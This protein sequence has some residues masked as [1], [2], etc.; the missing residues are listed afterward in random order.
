MKLSNG[1]GSV[2][3]PSGNR[4]KPYMARLTDGFNEKG[5]P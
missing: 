4:R 2:V 1:Y 3:K 5:H